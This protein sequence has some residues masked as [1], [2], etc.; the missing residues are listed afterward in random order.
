MTK[1]TLSYLLLFFLCLFASYSCVPP[2]YIPA[3][4]K[5][6]KSPQEMGEAS[7]QLY[8]LAFRSTDK[9]EKLKYAQG[10]IELAEKCLKKEKAP[11]CLYY[12]V[13]SRGI[14]IKNHIPNYQ[15]SLKKM[16]NDCEQLI[17]IEPYYGEAGCYRII[18]NIY[19]KAPTFSLNPKNITQ[20]IDKS[21]KYLNQAS[22]LAPNYP[23]NQLFLAQVLYK[24]EQKDRAINV[25]KKFESMNKAELDRDYPEWEKEFLKIKKDLELE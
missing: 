12:G 23:L 24:S 17:E 1:F 14:Y 9:K 8:Q 18:G 3:E 4:Y 7:K 20:D 15:R 16:I 19:A 22:Q 5:R 25:L 6:L 21:V 10:G 2:A 11:I 13:L